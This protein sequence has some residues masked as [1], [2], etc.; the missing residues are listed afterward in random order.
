MTKHATKEIAIGAEYSTLFALMML[1]GLFLALNL[2][3][4]KRRWFYYTVDTG[5]TMETILSRFIMTET[6]LFRHNRFLRTLPRNISGD[7]VLP[8]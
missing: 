4:Y 3:I 5:D 6:S 7:I 1:G 8:K 2:L